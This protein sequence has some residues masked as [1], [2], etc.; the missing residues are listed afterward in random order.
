MKNSRDSYLNQIK[1]LIFMLIIGCSK[2]GEIAKRVAR[3]L[4]K[5]Y[6]QLTVKK[7]PD[8][9][10]YIK[11]EADV[12]DKDVVLVQSF[13]GDVND[14]LVEVLFAAHTAKDLGAKKV[15]LVASYFPYFRQDYRF[16]EGECISIEVISKLLDNCLDEFIVINPHLHRKHSLN[17]VFNIKTKL[18][19]TDDLIYRY[20]KGKTKGYVFVGPDGESGQWV[21]K[22]ASK[23]NSECIVLE[24]KRFSATKVSVDTSKLRGLKG[25]NV[26]VLDD[27]VSTGNTLI[28]AA[29]GLKKAGVRKML[30]VTTHGLFFNDSIKKIRKYGD[31]VATNT[32]KNSVAKIDVSGLIADS[33]R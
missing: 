2:G 25:K 24:K 16:N 28:E 10:L 8:D 11:L 31:I 33:L 9:E 3:T 13:Y 18:L 22:I 1:L 7:F 27:M 4:K 5:E 12:R 30:F 15:R 19:L 23:L 6:S 26:V 21:C 32:V 17:E 20:L 14:L 29:K